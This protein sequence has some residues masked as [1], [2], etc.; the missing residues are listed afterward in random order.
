MQND[1]D[2]CGGVDFSECSIKH[3]PRPTWVCCLYTKPALHIHYLLVVVGIHGRSNHGVQ[4][5][6]V[7]AVELAAQLVDERSPLVERELDEVTC[8]IAPQVHVVNVRVHGLPTNRWRYIAQP[9]ELVRPIVVFK[10]YGVVCEPI[11]SY[12]STRCP[13]HKLELCRQALV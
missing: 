10:R 4:D 8:S 6:H 13:C 3:S 5:K 11:A 7:M 9:L 2:F 1:R 12:D